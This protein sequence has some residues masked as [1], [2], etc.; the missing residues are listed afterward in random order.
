MAAFCAGDMWLMAPP[1]EFE[2]FVHWGRK[3]VPQ[4]GIRRD[5]HPEARVIPAHPVV[6]QADVLV[7]PLAR[8]ASRHRHVVHREACVPEGGAL[9]VPDD[10]AL[11]VDGEAGRTRVPRPWNHPP[12]CVR[13]AKLV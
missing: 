2:H 11:C 12:G 1:C 4:Q 8:K 5:E 10:L 3:T 9:G 6:R 7:V 13:H